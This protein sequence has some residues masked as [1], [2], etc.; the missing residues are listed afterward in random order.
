[1]LGLRKLAQQ[2]GIMSP[3]RIGRRHG[4]HVPCTSTRY[5]TTATART[6]LVSALARRPMSSRVRCKGQGAGGAG[7]RISARTRA[8][9]AALQPLKRGARRAAPPRASPAYRGPGDA[10][11]PRGALTLLSLYSPKA[12]ER[13]HTHQGPAHELARRQLTPATAVDRDG[14]VVA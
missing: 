11:H 9:G 2:V 8:E 10:C 4:A 5:G 1:M 3:S 13:Q 12:R 7:A 14:G 6:R